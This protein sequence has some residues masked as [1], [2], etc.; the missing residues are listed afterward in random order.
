MAD[1]MKMINKESV[2]FLHC[3]PSHFI[4]IALNFISVLT[5]FGLPAVMTHNKQIV[6]FHIIVVLV[7]VFKESRYTNLEC[8]EI[9]CINPI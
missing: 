8:E 1:D 3:K 6:G 2:M 4:I 9:N 7:C 5:A